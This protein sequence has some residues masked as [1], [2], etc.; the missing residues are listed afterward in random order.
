MKKLCAT[1]MLMVA[2]IALSG[3]LDDDAKKS[4]KRLQFE[5]NSRYN[6]TIIP[7]TTEWERF[8]LPRGET[9]TLENVRDADFRFE[10]ADRV[11]QGSA[12]TARFI[13][14]VDSPP[15]SSN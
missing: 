13:V 14:F 7:L 1:L 6:I 12:S 3:C 9:R 15:S 2:V 10:P 5:N 8:V 4:A 11:Q